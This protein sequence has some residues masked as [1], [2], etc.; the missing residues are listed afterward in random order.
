MRQYAS[1]GLG[2]QP[3]R[4]PGWARAPESIDRETMLCNRE[5]SIMSDMS[6][7]GVKISGRQHARVSVNLGVTLRSDSNFYV[8]F[9]DNISEGGLFVAT[10][11]LLP[12]GSAITLEFRLPGDDEP[13]C[14]PAEVRW[15]RPVSDPEN[16][17]L[18]G[19]G[20]KFLEVDSADQ[21]RLDDFISSREPLFHPD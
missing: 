4:R 15:Q 11:D 19:F 8:G 7:E 1:Q 20:A 18:P 3:E 14:I 12:I 13:I 9:A 6:E 17:I 2:C 5:I 16:G 21:A 10:H